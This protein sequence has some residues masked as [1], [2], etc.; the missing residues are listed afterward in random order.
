MKWLLNIFKSKKVVVEEIVDTVTFKDISEPVISFLRAFDANPRRFKLKH[1]DYCYVWQRD[2][3]Y[4]IDTLTEED[5]KFEVDRKYT[6]SPI[7]LESLPQ[8]LTADEKEL[9]VNSMRG[10]YEGRKC[11]LREIKASRQKRKLETERDRL[12]LIYCKN[13]E[14]V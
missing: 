5:W 3:Y 1:F 4:L 9:I 14:G 11:K 12:K 13:M 2:T 7:R 8:Y 10:Y 6:N